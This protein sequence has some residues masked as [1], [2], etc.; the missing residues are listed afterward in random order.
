MASLGH[1]DDALLASQKSVDLSRKLGDRELLKE[2][3]YNQG[4]IFQKMEMQAAAYVAYHEAQELAEQMRYSLRGTEAR[5][6]F[7]GTNMKIYHKL[8]EVSL[9]LEQPQKIFTNI[10]QAKAR[11][12]IDLLQQPK[13]ALHLENG[14]DPD[15]KEERELA[16]K[17]EKCLIA[18]GQYD[19]TMPPGICIFG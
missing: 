13:I 10:E 1:R 6:A 7:T 8:I 19:K 12:L 5:I 9:A 14:D 3:L 16:G 18:L 17:L 4:R 11:A 15:L 2:Q